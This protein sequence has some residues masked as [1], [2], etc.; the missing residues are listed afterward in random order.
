LTFKW[1]IKQ[2]RLL[3]VRVRFRAQQDRA[4]R[5]TR[6]TGRVPKGPSRHALQATWV[7]LVLGVAAASVLASS[8]Y[9]AANTRAVTSFRDSAASISSAL[10]TTIRRDDDF[11]V[12]QEGMFE[13]FPGLTNAQYRTSLQAA[14]IAE[15]YPGGLGFSFIECPGLGFVTLPAT[16]P[17]TPQEV[18][19]SRRQHST[20]PSHPAVALNTASRATVSKPAG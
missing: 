6:G 12:S 1:F 16:W 18:Y 20:C 11:V 17:K 2:V 7:L 3:P 9:A 8:T 13:A 10:A 15:R 19:P 5:A 14:D 4:A